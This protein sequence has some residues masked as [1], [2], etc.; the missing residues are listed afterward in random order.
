MNRPDYDARAMK[1]IWT[2]PIVKF[3][4]LRGML[5]LLVLALAALGLVMHE[6][7]L[8][9]GGHFYQALLGR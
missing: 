7:N 4:G 9:S 1:R 2:T 5:L 6:E 8:S 3:L